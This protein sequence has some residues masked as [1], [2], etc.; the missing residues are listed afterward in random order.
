MGRFA[1][2][3]LEPDGAQ[4]LAPGA[5]APLYRRADTGER[6]TWWDAPI[7]AMAYVAG[8]GAG[9]D[10][11]TLMVKCPATPAERPDESTTWVIDRP[12]SSGAQGGWTRTGIPPKI[13]ANP[14]IFINPPGGWHGWLRDGE[15]VS[16]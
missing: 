13:T 3:M 16:V 5:L 10:G 1:C 4:E 6:M 11:R 12:S 15:L 2:F 8:L 14:S 9:P 7:G